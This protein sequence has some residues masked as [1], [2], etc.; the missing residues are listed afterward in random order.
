MEEVWHDP[1]IVKFQNLL[2]EPECDYITDAIG[3]QL[4]VWYSFESGKRKAKSSFR[5]MKK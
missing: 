4:H 1:Q 3:P 5:R 2:Y